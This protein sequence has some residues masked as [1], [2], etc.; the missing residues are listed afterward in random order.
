MKAFISYS[1]QDREYGRKVK[2][3]LSKMGIECFLAHEDVGVSEEWKKRI[4]EELNASEVFVAILSRAFRDSEWCSQELGIAY[5]K[6]NTVI[7]PL[8]IDDTVSYGFIEYLQSRRIDIAQITAFIFVTIL[9]DRYSNEVIS[10]MIREQNEAV[11]FRNAESIMEKIVPY[12]DRFNKR[13]ANKYAQVCIDNSQ[14]CPAHLCA[15]NYIPEFLKINGRKLS[16][17]RLKALQ[18]Q[19][20]EQKWYQP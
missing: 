4:I 13:Q 5:N 2:E 19:I 17:E 15:Q 10:F 14:I 20:E 6:P 11:S 18:Y 3:A 12:F 16:P 7:I 1:H 9:I 8:S